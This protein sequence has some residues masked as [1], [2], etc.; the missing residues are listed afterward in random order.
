VFL[1]AWPDTDHTTRIVFIICDGDEG[2]TSALFSAIA[3]PSSDD[4]ASALDPTH[5]LATPGTGP[6]E[7]G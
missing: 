6:F 5:P 7:P 1:D 4:A 3:A 2:A